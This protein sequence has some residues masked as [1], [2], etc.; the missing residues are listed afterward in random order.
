MKLHQA[1]VLLAFAAVL[2]MAAMQLPARGDA[3]SPANR[4]FNTRGE[5]VAGAHYIS[6][7]EKDAA[8]PNMVTVILA[9]YRSFDTLGETL[10]VFAGGIA[11][12]FILRRL[13]P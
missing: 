7:A 12:L 13:K 2:T 1:L 9:D 6:H 5:P 10:V 3:A 4:V 11:C 8:T